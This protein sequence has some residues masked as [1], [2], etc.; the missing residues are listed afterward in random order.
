ML[1][2]L[3]PASLRG[4][5]LLAA[6][7]ALG[8][9]AAAFDATWFRPLIQHHVQQRSGRQ[10]D[11]E[12]LRLGLDASLQ[13]TVRLTQLQVQNAAWAASRP[14]VRAAELGFTLSWESL[15]AD[16]IVLTRLTLVDAELDL[17]RQADGLRNW[18]LTRPNDRGPGRVRVLALDAQRT[19]ARVVH[20]GMALEITLRRTPLPPQ[21]TTPH[22]AAISTI[23]PPDLPLTRSVSFQGSSRG[24]P[25]EGQA[26]VSDVVTL[27]DTGQPFALRGQLRSARTSLGA[28]GRLSDVL[29]GAALDLQ[30]QLDSSRADELPAALGFSPSRLALPARLQGRLNKA[31][32]QWQLSALQARVGGSD[33]SG[34]LAFRERSA[35]GARPALRA[36]LSSVRVDWA[37]LRE[38]TGAGPA[39]KTDA[40]PATSATP[41]SAHR[42]QEIDAEIDWQIET[43]AGVLPTPLGAFSAKARLDQGRLRVA[44]LSFGVYGG[45]ASGSLGLDTRGS[46]PTATLDLNLQGLQLAKL[47][48]GRA[49]GETLAGGLDLR[50]ALRSQGASMAALRA[51]AAGTVEASLVRAS[52]PGTLEAKLGLDGG[53]WLRAAFGGTGRAPV[54]C[55]VLML[56][57][58][59]G[60]GRLRWLELETGRLSVSGTG[61]LDLAQQHI[62]MVLTPHRKQAAL[63]ALDRS[64]HVTGW[65]GRLGT[66]L[67][68]QTS[69]PRARQGCGPGHEGNAAGAS[70][71]PASAAPAR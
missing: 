27:F 16:T 36:Q 24:V 39:A 8:L 62:D 2:G 48:R 61:S 71:Q 51:A 19:Q 10:V 63:L 35:K 43:L 6:V 60:K 50:V 47:P 17:E 9:L 69:G 38:A 53:R 15:W 42:W 14:L 56:D 7:L 31:G 20:R 26:E 67:I 46:P 41:L 70:T 45:R 49:G 34:S 54:T 11:F 1:N 33:A 5:L 44:P 59:S 23:T 68:E 65:P 64:L 32:R 25:F 58:A 30:V 29:G 18:R 12:T 66:K 37:A 52:L 28:E 57:L 22:G 3:L 21:A 13:P 40:K 55:A 4:R